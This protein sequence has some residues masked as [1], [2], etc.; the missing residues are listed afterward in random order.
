MD[1]SSKMAKDAAAEPAGSKR[2]QRCAAREQASEMQAAAG[3]DL[4]VPHA[5]DQQTAADSQTAELTAHLVSTLSVFVFCRFA[6][7]TPVC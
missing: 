4:G 7:S 5:R 6:V 1:F 2:H 3:G